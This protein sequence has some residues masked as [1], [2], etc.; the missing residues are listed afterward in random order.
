M[1]LPKFFIIA[2]VS[3]FVVIG[4]MGILKKGK[5]S[6][7]EPASCNAQVIEFVE[8]NVSPLA[9]KA[10]PI[11]IEK[12]D[13]TDVVLKPIISPN[14][15]LPEADRIAS[16]F[17]PAAP[18]LPVVQTITYSSKVPWLKG[19]PAWVADYAS[20]YHTSRHFIARSLNGK[21]DYF[22]QNVVNGDRF[23]VLNPDINLEFHLVID[24]SRCKMWFYYVDQ[25][26]NERV[27]LK[28]YPVGLGRVDGNK[29]SG[30]LTPIGSYFLGDKIAV[31]RPGSMGYFN[32]QKTEMIRVFGTRWIPFEKEI[33]ECSAPAKG[34]GIHGAPWIF[35]REK[36]LWVE[37]ASGIGTYDSD[38]CIRLQQPDMEELFAIIVT[39][40]TYIHLVKDFSEAELPGTEKNY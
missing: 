7:K 20:H 2:T 27:L 5:H 39:K 40:P 38:G 35:D 37:D 25:D 19:R 18:K 33:G 22:T 4:V 8:E 31:Y 29:A 16:L 3:L 15:S 30:S 12:E 34:L 14:E 32:N 23:N 17:D 21:H 28:T 6:S 10:E 11:K 1:N 9:K 36:N 13:K 24:L 26:H